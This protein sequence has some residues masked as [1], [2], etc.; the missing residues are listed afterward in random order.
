[1]CF[2]QKSQFLQN[3]K[4]LALNI[5]TLTVTTRIKTIMPSWATVVIIFYSSKFKVLNDPL[6]L[7][8]WSWKF[9]IRNTFL[10]DFEALWKIHNFSETRF[11][12]LYYGKD[13][14]NTSHWLS[15]ERNP[16]NR[17]LSHILLLFKHFACIFG[18]KH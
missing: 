4:N 7:K 5:T 2:H 12:K 10:T 11:V 3:Y 16:N 6:F 18:E 17:L 1:M 13:G 9:V 14:E 15:S 8:K